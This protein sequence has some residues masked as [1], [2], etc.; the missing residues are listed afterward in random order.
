MRGMRPGCNPCLILLQRSAISG[1]NGRCPTSAPAPPGEGAAA[2][3][4]GRAGAPGRRR[5]RQLSGG[6]DRRARRFGGRDGRSEEHREGKEC[7]STCRYRWSTIHYKKNQR[8]KKRVNK[9]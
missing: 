5:A 7:V 6:G 2:S 4:S 1:G 9:K 3:R 8:S